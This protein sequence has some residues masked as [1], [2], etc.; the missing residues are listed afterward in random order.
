MSDYDA[1]LVALAAKFA[2]A[3][4][5]AEGFF[6][7][8]SLPER[9]HNPGDLE[10]GNRGWGVEQGK[11]IYFKADLESSL[12]D[13]ADGWA[14]LKRECVAILTGGSREYSPSDTFEEVSVKWTGGDNPGAWCKIVTDNLGVQPL[15]RLVDW[16]KAAAQQA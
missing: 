1:L 11:T 10:L 3:V 7:Q 14:A 16:V 13:R 5:L 15:D 9:V 4:A 2:H 6:V 8:G 12:D